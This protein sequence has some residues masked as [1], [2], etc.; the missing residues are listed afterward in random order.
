MK[1]NSIYIF[2][3]L[4]GILISFNSCQ[5]DDYELGDLYTPINLDVTYEIVG[6]DS[7]N[8][9]GDGS[10]VV[11]FTATAAN[12]ITYTYNF[13]DGTDV[14]VAPDGTTSH[15][16]TKTG[17]NEYFVT[18]T[19]VGTGGVNSTKTIS[20]EVY[21]SFTDDEAVQ[22]L[23]GGTSKSWYWAADKTGHNGVGPNFVVSYALDGHYTPN[24][25][26]AP[27]WV[28][29]G[30]CLYDGEFVF[31][32]V[33]GDLFFEHIN[34]TGQAMF[35][36]DNLDIVSGSAEGCYDYDFT[37]VKSVSL[38][39]SNSVATVDG[40]YRGTTFTISDGGFMGYYVG[41]SEYEIRSISETELQVRIVNK[42][43]LNNP[44]P[45]A[46]YHIFT[47]EKPVQ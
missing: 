34:P 32:L 33:D 38:S 2:V 4:I 18:V 41:N 11:N 10:G 23:T 43:S 1:N 40:E 46:F 13:G 6:L 7:E 21:S 44:E 26:P 20:L 29:S 39:P 35:N 14:D 25:W 37:G 42:G 31:S 8:P 36:V 5:Q 28:Y 12:E 15:M 9:Y 22:L 3:I 17:V 30:T 47:S 24:W 27:A 19:A 45:N 16:F